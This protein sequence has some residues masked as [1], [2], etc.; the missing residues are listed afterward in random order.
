MKDNKD[1]A[2]I[3][4]PEETLWKYE[5]ICKLNDIEYNMTRYSTYWGFDIDEE[6]LSK[7]LYFIDKQKHYID[8]DIL[9]KAGENK[10]RWQ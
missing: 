8:T 9:Q 4:L 1:I 6:N 2:T 5:W 3:Q 7:L 10:F